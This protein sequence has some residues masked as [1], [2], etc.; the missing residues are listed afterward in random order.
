MAGIGGEDHGEDH[1]ALVEIIGQDLVSYDGAADGAA[2]APSL[3]SE[4]LQ[5][6]VMTLPRMMAEALRARHR[7]EALRMAD[8]ADTVR[9]GQSSDPRKLIL[10]LSMPDGFEVSFALD[11]PQIEAL[12]TAGSAAG[13]SAHATCFNSGGK[14]GVGGWRLA[15]RRAGRPRGILLLRHATARA[16]SPDSVVGVLD[17]KEAGRRQ[18][19]PASL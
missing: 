19:R 6:R 8:P 11:A 3:P 1:M 13:L 5:T 15:S 4:C 7:G 18:L 9:V 14:A 16:A 2:C 10:T 17:E 12:G